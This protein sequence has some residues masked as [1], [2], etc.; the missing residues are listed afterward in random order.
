ML[1]LNAGEREPNQRFD[2]ALIQRSRFIILLILVNF[3][4]VFVSNTR[5]A[6]FDDMC[7][8]FYFFVFYL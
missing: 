2:I 4:C 7:K 3:N 8:Y 1:C 6:V 5:P